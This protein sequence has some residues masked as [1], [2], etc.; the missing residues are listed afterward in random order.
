MRAGW[1]SRAG[2]VWAAAGS[3]VGFGNLLKFPAALERGGGAFLLPLDA[4]A[5]YLVL[6]AAFCVCQLGC[7][8]FST[9]AIS[10]IQARTPARLMG[11]VMSFVTTLSMCAQPVGQ[12]AY[13]ALFD[14][15]AGRVYWVLI[16]SG[17]LV[18]AI[19]LA[20]SGFFARLEEEGGAA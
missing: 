5:R 18:C 7:S 8:V 12:I 3:A 10:V 11:K 4:A 17:L 9:C 20:S 6:L 19:G 15:A 2:L 13:G 14:L 16:P 1:S